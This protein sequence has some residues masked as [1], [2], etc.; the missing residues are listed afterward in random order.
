MKLVT[1]ARDQFAGG[2]VLRI[3]ASSAARQRL[4]GLPSELPKAALHIGVGRLD[5]TETSVVA[6]RGR[7]LR[8][9]CQSVRRVCTRLAV[10]R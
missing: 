5:K 10:E 6:K 3:E 1:D 4:H 2:M 8:G 9:C 7:G